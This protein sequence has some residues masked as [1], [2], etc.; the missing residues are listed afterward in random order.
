MPARTMSY[1]CLLT[2][3]LSLTLVLLP[4]PSGAIDDTD[5]RLA[6][7]QAAGDQ[8]AVR[9]IC[10]RMLQQKPSSTRLLRILAKVQLRSAEN[11]PCKATL[12]RLAAALGKPDADL[13]EM[14]GDLAS[15]GKDEP[16]KTD[17]A[18]HW[19]AALGLQPGRVSVINKLA[20][21][22]RSTSSPAEEAIYL[23]QLVSLRGYPDELARLA[24]HAVR[25][26]DWDTIMSCTARLQEKFA[27]R[28]AAK[29]WNPIYDRL[30][31]HSVSLKIIDNRLETEGQ[32]VATLL[33]RAWLFD[34]T[35]LNNLALS[36][37]EEAFGL[38]PGSFAVKYQLAVILAHAGRASDAA[39]RLHIEVSE[40]AQ[41]RLH[42]PTHFFARLT[43]IESRLASKPDAPAHVERARMLLEIR[44]EELALDDASAAV[45]IDPGF[46][47]AHLILARV[48]VS[49]DK[50][51]A[52][53]SAYNRILELDKDHLE[54]LGELGKLHM[55]LGDYATA[56]GFLKR[57]LD[58]RHDKY[59]QLAYEQ[60]FASLQTPVP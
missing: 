52:A 43:E 15:L 35:G 30:M 38:H 28:E 31:R 7:A 19:K 37:A 53:K 48:F 46:A 32:S 11:G 49:R 47:D 1:H 29:L 13:L 27:N 8:D 50:T 18:R 40:Y 41:K 14:R 4:P 16:A 17:A 20:N 42:P 57:R 23:E 6:R 59:L 45:A 34:R 9:E 21:Y 55:K 36:D 33:E 51:I 56:T 24:R 10:L 5:T 60:C 58:L 22:Y 44:Q 2:I 26:R 3:L 39:T 54:A 12:M 25:L